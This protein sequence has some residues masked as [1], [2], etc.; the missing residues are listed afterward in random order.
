VIPGVKHL[1]LIEHPE[2][3]QPIAQALGA[4]PAD[5]SK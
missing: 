4:H 5:T 2:I 3:W 1:R